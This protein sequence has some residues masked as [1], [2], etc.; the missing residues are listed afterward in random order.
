MYI[1]KHARMDFH[2]QTCRSKGG[3]E[4]LDWIQFSKWKLSTQSKSLQ[5][6]QQDTGQRK[7]NDGEC[8]SGAV[9]VSDS[10]A[11][12]LRREF[13]WYAHCCSGQDKCTS[14]C[15]WVWGLFVCV[16]VHDSLVVRESDIWV[17]RKWP[18]SPTGD[19]TTGDHTL[20]LCLL[21]VSQV[22]SL[23]RY[24]W[25]NHKAVAAEIWQKKKKKETKG[26]E[27]VNIL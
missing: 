26:R 21:L 6:N 3:R 18:V 7:W 20:T 12:Q 19:H 1:H 16:S 8:V 5:S 10:V 22:V 11:L 17:G 9:V 2:T 15:V 13:D 27:R 23:C 24:A 4:S 14:M 25:M